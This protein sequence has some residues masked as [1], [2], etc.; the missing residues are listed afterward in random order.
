MPTTSVIHSVDGTSFDVHWNEDGWEKLSF[1]LNQEH[2]AYPASMMDRWL[3]PIAPKRGRAAFDEVG[4]VNVVR[5]QF[6]GPFQYVSV[7]EMQPAELQQMMA[8]VGALIARHGSALG[9]WRNYCEPRARKAVADLD[10]PLRS[11]GMEE[12]AGVYAYGM[13]QTFTS[14]APVMGAMFPLRMMLGQR[15]GPE[16]A[17]LADEATQGGENASQ[18]VDAQLVALAEVARANPAVSRIMSER[19]GSARL[20]A[21]RAEPAATGFLERF[22]ALIAEHQGR[23]FGW[24]LT[25]PT[26]GEDPAAVLSMVALHARSEN[27][28]GTAP[29][30]TALRDA[31]RERVTAQLT[32]PELGQFQHFVGMLDGL[33]EI[34]ED[35]A[36]WQM[37]LHG[38]MRLLLL[39]RGQ[40]LVDSGQLERPDDILHLVPEEFENGGVADLDDL[41][42]RR[43]AEWE[44]LKSVVPPTYIGDGTPQIAVPPGSERPGELRGI[45]VSRGT[46]TGTARII[47]EP[48]DI[49]RF[50]AGDILVCRMTTPAWTPLFG[51]AAAVVTETGQALSHP[52]ITAREY[53]IPCVLS[54]EG[55]VSRIADGSTITVDGTAGVVRLGS[56]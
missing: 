52:A 23:S 21:L 56:G 41:A 19:D 40:A 9:F 17:L 33:V 49:D 8:A 35:R 29:T 24:E 37:R 46:A 12:L 13:A 53:G 22:D 5:T 1:G 51:L 27:P 20:E 50:N 43:R 16:G 14:L 7:A 15:F 44:H 47:H 6:A 45:G 48:E 38:A 42:K 2:W 39:E 55:A 30:S 10:G 32:G 26:W 28:S 3:D 31:A 36:Y 11:A 34:R 54:V 25:L 18:A 4:L